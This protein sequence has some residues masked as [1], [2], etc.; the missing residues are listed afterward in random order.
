MF[1]SNDH[2]LKRAWNSL[3]LISLPSLNQTQKVVKN[4]KQILSIG[5]SIING[6]IDSFVFEVGVSSDKKNIS[7]S[8][9]NF[10][11]YKDTTLKIKDGKVACYTDTVYNFFVFSYSSSE[12]E[13]C[14]WED[15]VEVEYEEGGS[16][17][18]GPFEVSLDGYFIGFSA[19]FHLSGFGGSFKIG[20][21]ESW[22]N[23]VPR[24]K[25]N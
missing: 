2:W 6:L 20:L 13:I 1:I 7:Y 3:K 15:G 12:R 22:D 10:G 8:K 25:F 24:K 11:K 17:S 9:A 4:S 21:F 5:G 14:P 19:D 18:V 23:L 16:V